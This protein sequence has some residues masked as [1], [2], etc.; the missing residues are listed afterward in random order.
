MKRGFFL[1]FCTYAIVISIL[2][3]I[4]IGNFSYLFTN[5]DYFVKQLEK[6]GSF[7][8]VEYAEGTNKV[9]IDYLQGKSDVVLSLDSFNER[10]KSHLVDVKVLIEHVYTVFYSSLVILLVC[11]LLLLR[12]DSQFYS[13]LKSIL[14]YTGLSVI[15]LG[16]LLGLFSLVFSSTFSVFH[17][18]F[19][20]SGTWLFNPTD[21]LILLYPFVFFKEFFVRIVW[22]SVLVGIFFVLFSFVLRYFTTNV[23]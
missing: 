11:L 4:F 3:C 14:L 1:I 21:T 9:V 2:I 23:K 6:H 12:F 7:D 16:L 8:R 22:D 13:T 18:V 17:Q 5:E 19:F 20:K 10:E 15:G